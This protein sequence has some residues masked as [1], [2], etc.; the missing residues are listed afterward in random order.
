LQVGATATTKPAD[1]APYLNYI[2]QDTTSVL[3]S[4]QQDSSA[5]ITCSAAQPCYKFASGATV[6]LYNGYPFG[7]TTNTDFIWYMIDLDGRSN[8]SRT[9]SMWFCLYYNGR[10]VSEENLV[11]S[12]HNNGS[13][14]GPVAGSD[15]DWFSW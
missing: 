3:D 9:D 7:G 1:L 10:V 8:G 13:T 11:A 15:P 4:P 6:L 5:T 12:S 14:F 2:K